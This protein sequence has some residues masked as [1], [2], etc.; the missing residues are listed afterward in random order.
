M[1]RKKEGTLDKISKKTKE[2]KNKAGS[3]LEK[4]KKAVCRKMCKSK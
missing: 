3:K 2:L 4:A 1:P